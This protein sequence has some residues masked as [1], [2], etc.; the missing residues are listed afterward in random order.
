MSMTWKISWAWYGG[1]MEDSSCRFSSFYSCWWQGK[2]FFCQVATWEIEINLHLLV[3]DSLQIHLYLHSFL[4]ILKWRCVT[5]TVLECP[6]CFFVWWIPPSMWYAY[7]CSIWQKLFQ[8]SY[9]HLQIL[10]SQEA[11]EFTLCQLKKHRI[12]ENIRDFC[13]WFMV[14]WV[15]TGW[16]VAGWFMAGWFTVSW[17]M[18]GWFMVSWFMA[19]WFTASWFMAGWFT[20]S[21]FLV[22]L[23]MAG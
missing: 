15:I 7:H 9:L 18:A 13:G 23:F 17:F 3:I 2:W 22:S 11:N 4:C 14:D 6:T 1:N 12:N 20:V 5:V 10:S 8:L 21:W 16:F 19:G